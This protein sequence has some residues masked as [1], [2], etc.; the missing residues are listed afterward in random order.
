[1]IRSAR[2]FLVLTILCGCVGCDQA[3]KAIARERLPAGTTISMLHDTVRLVRTENV[4]AFL[5]LG[6]S[7]PTRARVPRAETCY[8]RALA[9][10]PIRARNGGEFRSNRNLRPKADIR[11][12]KS[13]LWHYLHAPKLLSA[14]ERRTGRQ[15]SAPKRTDS[16]LKSGTMLL[17]R[18]SDVI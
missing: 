16:C 10:K 6:A 13:G 14:R 1:M 18:R 15:L 5:S 8:L 4:G 9:C 11:R 12:F 3:T 17:P 7:L 2:V